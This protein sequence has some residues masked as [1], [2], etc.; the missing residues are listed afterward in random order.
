MFDLDASKL[1]IIGVFALL[2]LGPKELPRVMRQVGNAVG[3]MRRMANEF[4]GQFMDAMR[5]SEL[6]DLKKE[7][8]K[9]QESAKVDMPSIEP[10]AGINTDLAQP[11]EAKPVETA[12]VE[13][14]AE[15]APLDLGLPPAPEAPPVASSD[16]AAPQPAESVATAEA[17]QEQQPDADHASSEAVTT[18]PRRRSARPSG[19]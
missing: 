1:L 15:A 7:M 2:F 17:G 4:Q 8:N 10:F 19:A 14:A 3:K 6:E 9:L 16:L 12:S 13:T 11:G 5:E 18:E